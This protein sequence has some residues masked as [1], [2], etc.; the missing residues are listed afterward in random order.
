VFSVE[1]IDENVVNRGPAKAA[2]GKSKGGG[3]TIEE[4]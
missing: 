3:K 1:M 4:M 2:S